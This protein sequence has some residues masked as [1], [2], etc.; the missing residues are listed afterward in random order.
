MK[1][2]LKKNGK[3]AL[4]P[5]FIL[6]SMISHATDYYISN[7][8]SDSNSGLS[9][10][11]PWATIAKVN[12]VAL[13]P[14]D[15]VLF[16]RGDTFSG[17]LVPKS[18]STGGQISYSAYGTGSNPVISGFET[19]S[20]W[21]SEGSGIYSAPTTAKN[22][23]NMVII[24]DINVPKGRY[25]N[26][27]YLTFE[28]FTGSTSITDNQLTGTPNWTD[29]EIVIRPNRWTLE[30][31]T[32]TDHTN[33]TIAFSALNYSLTSGYGY[34]IQNDIKTL[35][36][37]KEWYVKDGK[38]YMYFGSDIPSNHVVKV[39]KTDVLVNSVNKSYWSISNISIEGA[40]DKG[41]KIYNPISV[42]IENCSFEFCG[43]DGIE[44][45]GSPS[46]S[47]LTIENNTFSNINTSSIYSYSYNTNIKNNFIFNI[48]LQEGMG[49]R[50]WG[51]YC[52][53]SSSGPNSTIQYNSV[54]NSGYDG[55]HFR[56]SNTLIK[57][58]L[59][60]SFCSVIDDG[61]G[62]YTAGVSY[63]GRVIDGNIIV[64]G[65]E[66]QL[67]TP[68]ST[69]ATFGIY[70]DEGA[71]DITVSNNT[72]S[73]VT[74]GGIV[75]HVA[76][77]VDIT[78]NTVYNCG[79][80]LYFSNNQTGV[81][82]S[83]V[84]VTDNIF[85]AKESTQTCFSFVSIYNDLAFGSANNNIYARPILDTQ[86]FSIDQYNTNA[87]TYDLAGW[88]TLSGYD[89]GSTKSPI[90][91]SDISDF[92]FEYNA[93]QS[94][95][96]I[97]LAQPMVDSKGTK[98]STSIILQPYASVVLMKDISTSV[99]LI[100]ENELDYLKDSLQISVFPNP[101]KGRITVSFSQLPEIG[102][103]I[104]IID[105]SGRVVAFRNI[106][107]DSEEFNL[108]KFIS[109]SYIVRSMLKSTI[110]NQGIITKYSLINKI[111]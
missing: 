56:G 55:I 104:E 45:D 90:T 83:S 59:I 51:N 41:M 35:D 23:L 85:I 22:T 99:N 30:N 64:N 26:S 31:R 105:L 96:T 109:G 92:Q 1:R 21:T 74:R 71:A 76:T 43:N 75:L 3:I 19:L 82:M 4:V 17:Q 58:N 48:G 47:D 97:A 66:A 53:I 10:E 106:T 42:S 40:N 27:G 87:I 28:S 60:D 34:F 5:F 11:A 6:F 15:M 101:S 38:F 54:I 67:G 77:N 108:E 100:K 52:G 32:I 7:S 57:N 61:G 20:S 36:S 63:T 84:N 102:S 37:F 49:Q 8:G 111:L 98:Y 24:D 88:K 44:S 68:Y 93:S 69:S 91:I 70:L 78:G 50:G 29:A 72:V 12:S 14:G 89:A 79:R 86:T 73:N 46:G 81:G 13:S 62:I 80:Q 33:S 2:I 9:I 25:P 110:S 65:K 94:S 18:G 95:K 107:K 16:K 103:R 39:A